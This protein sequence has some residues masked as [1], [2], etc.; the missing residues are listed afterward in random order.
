VIVQDSFEVAMHSRRVSWLATATGVLA[1]VS[2][3]SLLAFFA[4]GGPSRCVV[5]GAHGVGETDE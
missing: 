3:A 1:V 5:T 2:L 4:V